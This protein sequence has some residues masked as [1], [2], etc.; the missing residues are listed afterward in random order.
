M[1]DYLENTNQCSHMQIYNNCF[2]F[3]CKECELLN[4]TIVKNVDVDCGGLKSLKV[5]I[6]P[7]VKSKIVDMLDFLTSEI[8]NIEISMT[9]ENGEVIAKILDGT[10]TLKNY[11]Y[12]LM[13]TRIC[14]DNQP[15]YIELEFVEI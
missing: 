5:L 2:K 15:L 4:D 8:V 13:R 9:N 6:S 12:S 1:K 11:K 3:T 7:R 14:S 10:Y